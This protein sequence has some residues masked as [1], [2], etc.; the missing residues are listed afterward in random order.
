MRWRMDS[1]AALLPRLGAGLA[2]VVVAFLAY[3]AYG[4]P[5]LALAAGGLVMWVLLNMTRMLKVLQ[6]AAERPVGTVASAVMLHSRLSQGMTL[7]Q[8]LALTRALGQRLG[9]AGAT[10]ESYEW[11]DDASA[12]VRCTFDHGKLTHWDLIRS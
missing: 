9:E 12:I 5:G 1:P 10:S 4:W 3:R 6:R 7:L 2:V 11:V 8:V